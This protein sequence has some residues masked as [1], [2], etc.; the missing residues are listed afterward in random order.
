[1]ATQGQ[2]SS[3]VFAK[4]VE[5]IMATHEK[6]KEQQEGGEPSRGKGKATRGRGRGGRRGRGSTRTT[7]QT[8][9]GTKGK[10]R[11]PKE[12]TSGEE[13]GGI[14]ELGSE[15]T[16]VEEDNKNEEI[17]E[18]EGGDQ[19][20]EEERNGGNKGGEED[21]DTISLGDE[22]EFVNENAHVDRDH[23]RYIAE[24]MKLYERGKTGKFQMLESAYEKWCEKVKSRPR[25][26]EMLNCSSEEEEV[27]QNALKRKGKGQATEKPAKIGKTM[28]Q[29]ITL[30]QRLI[31]LSPYWDGRMTACF[32]YVPLTIF[33]PACLLADKT[34]MSN[35]RKQNSSCSDIISY[36]GLRVPNEWRQSF[37]MW[38]TSFNLYV[39]Y[40][41]V[42]YHLGGAL[43]HVNPWTGRHQ[44]GWDLLSNGDEQITAVTG[45]RMLSHL[46]SN[47]SNRAHQQPNHQSG[48]Y[49]HSSYDRA[50]QN[51]HQN[52][53][54]DQNRFQ[55]QGAMNQGSGGRGRGRRGRG[56]G[57]RGG[58]ARVAVNPAPTTVINGV[59]V[60]KYGPGA[61]EAL[62]AAKQAGGSSSA[63]G[64]NQ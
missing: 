16:E 9:G 19:K 60:P 28:A 25:P 6:E 39:Q 23:E 2:S 63:T 57:S 1:M 56:I 15:L 55:D 24:L 59:V 5:Q 58:G 50:G 37:L 26:I 49:S 27:D 30:T 53:N 7:R 48:S 18:E 42:K 52:Y 34:H 64:P 31:D 12:E 46:A 13:E 29:G 61:F 51:P 32:G 62:K 11:K 36:V 35:R 20:E 43:E 14:E 17:D 8:R 38:S 21:E 40:W 54:Y 44:V 41:R 4:D 47:S 45:G 10:I 22:A 33:V 3:E